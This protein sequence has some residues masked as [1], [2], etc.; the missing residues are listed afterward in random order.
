[1]FLKLSILRKR[2]RPAASQ[3][4]NIYLQ[5]HLIAQFVQSELI[6]IIYVQTFF[7]KFF[8]YEYK[9]NNDKLFLAGFRRNLARP[10]AAAQPRA[11][12]FIDR[13]HRW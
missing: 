7:F 1:M 8:S 6:R 11:A 2:T 4:I 5:I 9:K 10:Q 3:N 12:S 13:I